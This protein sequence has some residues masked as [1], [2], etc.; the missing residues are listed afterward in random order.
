KPDIPHSTNLHA[1]HGIVL[2]HT[3]QFQHLSAEE[4]QVAHQHSTLHPLSIASNI[5][6]PLIETYNG[7]PYSYSPPLVFIEILIF[8]PIGAIY[9]SFVYER[10]V[11][12]MGDYRARLQRFMQ[13]SEKGKKGG[14]ELPPEKE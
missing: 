4:V 7:Q 3:F 9:S 2:R 1:D 13:Q 6:L 11:L 8:A 12:H 5:F 10:A 14:V